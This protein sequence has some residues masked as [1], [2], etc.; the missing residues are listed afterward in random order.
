M[1]NDKEF[2]KK[3]TVSFLAASMTFTTV[4]GNSAVVAEQEAGTEETT[5]VNFEAADEESIEPV[6]EGTTEASAQNDVAGAAE[7]PKTEATGL[8]DFTSFAP[9]TKFEIDVKTAFIH[10]R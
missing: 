6:A 3:F 4:L 5:A 1:R 9:D 10:L 8:T 7:A 2:W